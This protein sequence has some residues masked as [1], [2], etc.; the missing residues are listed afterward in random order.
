[1]SFGEPVFSAGFI[2]KTVKGDL[3]VKGNYG[4]PPRK[5]CWKI[6]EDSRRLSTKAN[7]EGLPCGVGRPHLQAVM[8]RKSSLSPP[9]GFH[10]QVLAPYVLVTY[11]Q[12]E[13][14]LSTLLYSIRL[15]R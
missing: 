14:T 8:L 9:G 12:V 1:M 4:I 10:T 15:T 7:P 13:Q 5:Q 6:L 11:S 3:F 2:Q